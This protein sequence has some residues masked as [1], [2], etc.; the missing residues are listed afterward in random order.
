MKIGI[1]VLLTA[2]WLPA[3]AIAHGNATAPVSLWQ[4]YTFDTEI[5]VPLLIFTVL[6]LIGL[7]RIWSR[8]GVGRGVARWR[9]GCFAAGMVAL[10]L[11]L[12][13]PFDALGSYS[14]AAHMT[15]HVLL[16]TFAAPLLVL[17]APVVTLLWGLPFTWRRS[18]AGFGRQRH[19]RRGRN[20]LTIPVIAW[21]GYALALWLWHTPA[22]YQAAVRNETLHILEHVSF[23]ASALLLWWTALVS[24]RATSFGFGTGV[25]LLFTTSLQA[26][27]LGALLTFARRPFYPIYETNVFGLTPVADQQLAGIIMW[28][29]GGFVYLGGALLLAW[30][31]LRRLQARDMSYGGNAG[32]AL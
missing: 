6:Y 11:A 31:W 23:L 10:I 25:F 2:L 13:W 4:A 17:A 27:L 12:V 18:L 29:P 30:I 9:V 15:Q 21:L 28:I 26:G 5:I 32:A 14:L 7:Q 20:V 19:I 22:A 16:T 1:P 24:V 3:T 8:A